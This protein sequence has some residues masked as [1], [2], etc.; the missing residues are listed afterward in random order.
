MNSL[1]TSLSAGALLIVLALATERGPEATLPP[2]G[3]AHVG[4]ER[5]AFS[6]ESLDDVVEEYCVRCHS[7]RRLTGN[8]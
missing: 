8:M 3:S 5:P 6:A 7:D 1:L 4:D 2:V